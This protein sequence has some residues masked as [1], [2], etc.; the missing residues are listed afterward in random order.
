MAKGGRGL[1][2][3]YNL[4]VPNKPA[5]LDDYL[6]EMTL[7]SAQA[8]RM[9]TQRRDTSPKV[10]SM[11]SPVSADEPSRSSE[12]VIER[13]AQAPAQQARPTRTFSRKQLNLNPET[14]RMVEELLEQIRKSSAQ[15]DAKSSE[16]FHALVSALYDARHC[17]WFHDLPIRGRWGTPAARAF[18]IALKQIFQRAIAQSQNRNDK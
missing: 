15:K 14:L 18:P 6:D 11:Q 10:V 17:L 3:N 8:P 9:A 5:E 2:S 4:Q 16:M 13:A 12:V 7:P 1:P